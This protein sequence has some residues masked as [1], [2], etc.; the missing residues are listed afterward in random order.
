MDKDIANLMNMLN[1]KFGTNAVRTGSNLVDHQP[2]TRIKTGNVSLDL[3]LGGGIPVGRYTEI[4]GNF[5]STKTTQCLHI[6]SN[7]QKMGYVIAMVD[8]EGTTSTEKGEPD[9]HFLSY[10]D[11]N[12]ENFVFNRPES[13]EEATQLILE[14]Q[15]SGVVNV[16]LLDS[17]AMLEPNKVLDS[18]M[19]DTVQMGVKQKLLG[20]FFAKFQMN[21]NKLTREGKTPFTLICTNQIREKIGGYGD[22]EYTPGGRAKGFASSVDIRLR[23]GDLLVNNKKIVGQVVKFKVNKNKTYPRLKT[24]EFDMYLAENDLG[25]RP[26]HSDNVRSI[27]VEGIEAKLITQAGAWFYLDKEK[28][29][30]FQGIDKLVLFIRE[31]PQWIEIL[32]NQIMPEEELEEEVP[33]VAVPA[34]KSKKKKRGEVVDPEVRE[35]KIV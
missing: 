23:Q 25:V 20:E 7:A 33:E 13:L 30:K 22:S 21:N 12:L 15:K 32:R 14:M 18:D 34:Q 26:F 4:S 29:L 10:F 27:I 16:C 5:S 17:L 35:E 24:G 6:L 9:S 28:E 19:E 11:I 8:A 3:A 1:K 2:L 31:N